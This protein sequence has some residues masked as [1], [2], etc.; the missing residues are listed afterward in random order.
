MLLRQYRILLKRTSK[1]I[2]QSSSA[3]DHSVHGILYK[4][5]AGGRKKHGIHLWILYG[6]IKQLPGTGGA[7]ALRTSRLLYFREMQFYG[8]IKGSGCIRAI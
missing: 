7:G 5:S 1:K 3:T 4:K 2:H 6:R 8:G